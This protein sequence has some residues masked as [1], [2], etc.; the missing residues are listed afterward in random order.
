MYEV[1]STAWFRGDEVTITSEP[2]EMDGAE[3]QNAVYPDGRKII[4]STPKQRERNAKRYRAEW[5]SQQD[6][7]RRLRER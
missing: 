1:G 4:L 3:W 2:Y 5:Q 7:F 6:G